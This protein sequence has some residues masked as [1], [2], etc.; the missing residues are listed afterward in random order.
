MDTV[1]LWSWQGTP[2][3]EQRWLKFQML[4]QAFTRPQSPQSSSAAYSKFTTDP[5]GILSSTDISYLTKIHD[6]T[7][8]LHWW[9]QSGIFTLKWVCYHQRPSLVANPTPLNCSL[10]KT[11]KSLSV[12]FLLFYQCNLRNVTT[13]L[14]LK[15]KHILLDGW[16]IIILIE[17]LS[18]FDTL[19]FPLM[20][21][22]LLLHTRNWPTS[23]KYVPCT[24]HVRTCSSFWMFIN[25]GDR[26][27]LIL[28]EDTSVGVKMVKITN[29]PV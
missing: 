25:F 19:I 11:F 5:T 23:H 20:I 22:R 9:L 10:L 15:L 21:F 14:I 26:L 2:L 29:F 28:T 17:T 27:S 6:C 1:F 8:T 12:L 24:S 18:S 4:F 3:S 13:N 7:T 16:I